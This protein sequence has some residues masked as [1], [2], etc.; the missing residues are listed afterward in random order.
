MSLL[1][2]VGMLCYSCK[3]DVNLTGVPTDTLVVYGLFN[4]SDSVHHLL[5][6]RAVGGKEKSAEELL[7]DPALLYPSS[8]QVMIS[9]LAAGGNVL[10]QLTFKPETVFAEQ[11]GVPFRILWRARGLVPRQAATARL[12]VTSENKHY[13]ATST[14]SLLT[15]ID[16]YSPSETDTSQVID[17][18]GRAP[19]RI[20]WKHTSPAVIYAIEVTLFYREDN[21]TTTASKKVSWLSHPWIDP[22]IETCLGGTCNAPL[23]LE[24]FLRALKGSLSADASVVRQATHLIV[25]VWA[26]DN[27]FMTYRKVQQA[28]TFTLT[29]EQSLPLWGNIDGALGLF[30]VVYSESTVPHRLSS[31]TI[32]SIACSDLSRS[33]NFKTSAGTLCQ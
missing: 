2:G 8:L 9:V 5:I 26:G 11:F 12:T 22:G 30:A 33:L 14:I 6:Y 23:K 16:I 4:P 31:S 15:N 20:L 18:S 21:G 28:Q 3:P 25:T 13:N 24:D 32:D 1:V 7:A 19:F 10:S 29:A 17:L 27:N